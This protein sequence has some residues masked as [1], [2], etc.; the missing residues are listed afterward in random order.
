MKR[1]RRLEFTA[2]EPRGNR[3]HYLTEE[4]VLVLQGVWQKRATTG[5][6]EFISAIGVAA[7]G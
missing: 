1:M 5:F 3:R 4:D 6:S 2:A 7:C